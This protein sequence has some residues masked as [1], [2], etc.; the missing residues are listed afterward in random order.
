MR[1]EIEVMLSVPGVHQW[2]EA[3]ISVAYLRVR[4]PHTF[5]IRCRKLVTGL[6]REIEF[7]ILQGEIREYFEDTFPKD[8]HGRYLLVTGCGEDNPTMSCEQLAVRLIE[9]FKLSYCSVF[10]D[11]EN[12]SV[13]HA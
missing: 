2:L 5:V 1:T 7:H 6:D 9:Q 11:G 10:E 12:G 3:P 13:V 8:E 4:H